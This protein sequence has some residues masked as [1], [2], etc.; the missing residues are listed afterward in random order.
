MSALPFALTGAQTRVW[1][2]IQADLAQGIPMNRLLQ[3]DVGSGKTVVAALA[4]LRAIDHGLQAALMAPTE[5]LAEQHYQRLRGW[6]EPLGLRIVWLTGSLSK[7]T[8]EAAQARVAAGE[9]DLVIGTHALIQN[10]VSFERLGVVV[11][12]EQH[13]FGVAQRLSLRAKGM[14]VDGIDLQ[15]HLLM[16]SATPIPRTLAMTYLAD[17]D[18]SV[19]DALPP[20]RTPIQTTVMAGA[21]RGELVARVAAWLAQGKQAYWVTP[22]I[23][24][25]EFQIGRA[26]C[27]ERV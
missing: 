26:S 17:L 14:T 16:M 13:R 5:I 2:E 21:K 19:I 12:D 23:E 8:K 7:K 1:D 20:G 6:L 27:R 22:L 15:P 18:V 4:C 25:S 3:G 9:C 10:A 11:V 24:E